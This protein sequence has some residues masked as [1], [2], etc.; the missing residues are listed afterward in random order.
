MSE[1]KKYLIDLRDASLPHGLLGF[2]DWGVDHT[3]VLDVMVKAAVL[4]AEDS[5]YDFLEFIRDSLQSYQA[6]TIEDLYDKIKP[7]LRET[8]GVGGPRQL[9]SVRLSDQFAAITFREWV[10]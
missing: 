4:Q 9:E 6:D 2:P 7:L 8:M 3:V 1:L 5:F 10:I